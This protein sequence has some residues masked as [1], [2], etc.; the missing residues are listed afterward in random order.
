MNLNIKSGRKI[1]VT[2]SNI[3]YRGEPS[4]L[5]IIIENGKLFSLVAEG[6]N[7]G[8]YTGEKLAEITKIYSEKM[9]EKDIAHHPADSNKLFIIGSCL[10]VVIAA[11]LL[12]YIWSKH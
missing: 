9:M 11:G 8:F 6:K 7:T 5:T 4:T 12:I 3:A 2:H 1:Y 10:A